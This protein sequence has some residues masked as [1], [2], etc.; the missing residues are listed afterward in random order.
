MKLVLFLLD[1]LILGA[2]S[3]EPEHGNKTDGPVYPA[4]DPRRC[5]MGQLGPNFRFEVLP[6]GGWDNLRNKEMGTLVQ[7]NFSECR[8]TDDG[9]FLLPDGVYTIPLKSSKVETY[10]ELIEHWDNFTR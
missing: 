9:R 5:L 10:A 4:G 2:L 1:F 6:G 7:V 8:T 3:Q